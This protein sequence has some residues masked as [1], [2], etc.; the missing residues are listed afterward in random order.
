MENSTYQC[1][2]CDK[3]IQSD[4]TGLVVVTNWEKDKNSQQ[5]QQLFCH[6]KCLKNAVSDKFPLYIADLIE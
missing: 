3:K 2:F 6:M 4:V 1:C 5:E